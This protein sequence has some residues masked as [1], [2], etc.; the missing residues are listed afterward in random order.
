MMMKCNSTFLGAFFLALALFGCG[1]VFGV[2][3]P[4]GA[5]D[6]G[7]P[8]AVCA[9][10]ACVGDLKTI[11]NL[12]RG[13]TFSTCTDKTHPAPAG[14]TYASVSITKDSG[15][16]SQFWDAG[17]KLDTYWLYQYLRP[18]MSCQKNFKSDCWEAPAANKGCAR[19]PVAAAAAAAAPA[20]QRREVARLASASEGGAGAGG[21][22]KPV[23]L[24]G[25]GRGSA[26]DKRPKVGT[27]DGDLFPLGDPS[28]IV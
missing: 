21:S 12:A 8:V 14:I 10:P 20:P 5:T 17:T 9:I 6:A 27:R 2:A 11:S 23:S 25:G 22:F 4:P 7:S 19:P 3:I 13:I 1:S 28:L 15:F 24:M 16:Q 26:V 18:F